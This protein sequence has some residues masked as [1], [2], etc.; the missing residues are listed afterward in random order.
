M[1]EGILPEEEQQMMQVDLPNDP[2]RM[3]DLIVEEGPMNQGTVQENQSC[4]VALESAVKSC[5]KKNKIDVPDVMTAFEPFNDDMSR[6]LCEKEEVIFTCINT[7]LKECAGSSDETTARGMLE[8]TTATVRDMCTMREMSVEAKD[9]AAVLATI[10]GK[11]PLLG[12]ESKTVTDTKTQDTGAVID[13]VQDVPKKEPAPENKEILTS[14]AAKE[15][16]KQAIKHEVHVQE[17]EMREYYLPILIGSGVGFV[18]LVLV[19][20]LVI[21]CCCKI[22]RAHV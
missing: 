4:I 14:A 15:M 8:E 9:P 11:K 7:A 20:S 22:G 2:V 13:T 16:M 12:S 1:Q 21:C 18:I 5:L 3:P 19:L 10:E 17:V 6:V